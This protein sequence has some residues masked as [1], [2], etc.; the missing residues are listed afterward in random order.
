MIWGLLLEV[1]GRATVGFVDLL[2]MRLSDARCSCT[3]AGILGR[4]FI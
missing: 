4:T 2:L 3:A 1:A